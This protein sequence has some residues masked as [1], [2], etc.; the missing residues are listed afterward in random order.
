MRDARGWRSTVPSLLRIMGG[1]ST[2][3]PDLS[4]I[5]Y[6]AAVVWDMPQKRGSGF[7]QVV[8]PSCFHY[9]GRSS[10]SQTHSRQSLADTREIPNGS[11]ALEWT[12]V[13]CDEPLHREATNGAN[14][15]GHGSLAGWRILGGERTSRKA[16]GVS[17]RGYLFLRA[18]WRRRLAITKKYFILAPQFAF[19]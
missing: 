14:R 7:M 19:R 2:K 1:C 3:S 16:S 6:A 8:I 10:V 18:F 5:D 13:V 15:E 9:A 11:L 12:R 17:C 4:E